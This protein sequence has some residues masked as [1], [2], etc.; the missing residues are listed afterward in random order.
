MDLNRET[1]TWP[2]RIMP[3]FDE[4]ALLLERVKHKGEQMLQ[5]KREKILLEIEKVCCA[6]GPNS[7]L[8]TLS[9]SHQR[10]YP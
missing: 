10:M 4:S 8:V 2:T 6:L 3:V 7:V 1:T 9:L 5:S